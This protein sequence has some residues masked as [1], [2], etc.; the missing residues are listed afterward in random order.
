MICRHALNDLIFY[1]EV[2]GKNYFL[3]KGFYSHLDGMVSFM[4][5]AWRL[6]CVRLWRK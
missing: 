1:Q 4:H 6:P 5:I 2:Y 3:K